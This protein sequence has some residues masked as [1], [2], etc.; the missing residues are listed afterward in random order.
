MQAA[1][2]SRSNTQIFG[3]ILLNLTA[4]TA[5][6]YSLD[7]GLHNPQTDIQSSMSGSARSFNRLGDEEIGFEMAQP[8]IL[9]IGW[10]GFYGNLSIYSRTLQFRGLV[11]TL[12]RF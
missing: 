5:T 1:L 11:L 6:N 3:S 8:S 12:V 4:V 2:D 10:I 9:Q 7:T